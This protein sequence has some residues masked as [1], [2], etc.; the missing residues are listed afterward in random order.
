MWWLESLLKQVIPLETISKYLHNYIMIMIH[1]QLNSQKNCLIS[2]D[3]IYF[4][5][6]SVAFLLGVSFQLHSASRLCSILDLISTETRSKRK[7]RHLLNWSN[8]QLTKKKRWTRHTIL[9]WR[10]K[11]RGNIASNSRNQCEGHGLIPLLQPNIKAK[12]AH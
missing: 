1:I 12:G 4:C 3:K 7:L 10:N 5:Y 9:L 2:T 11:A 8:S 6:D